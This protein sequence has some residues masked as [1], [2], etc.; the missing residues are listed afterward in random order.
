MSVRRLIL[1]CA[2]MAA[3]ALLLAALTPP[4]QAITDSLL[5]PQR[6]VDARGADAL[7]LSAAG[8]ASWA[9]WA[10]ATLG[11]ALTTASAVP[12]VLGVPAQVLLRVVLPA[13]ARRAAALALGLGL[14]APVVL[15]APVGGHRVELAVTTTAASVPDWPRDDDPVP[16]WPAAQPADFHVVV[17]GD[18]LWD[19]VEGRLARSGTTPTDSVIAGAVRAWWSANDQVIGPNPDLILPGQVLRAPQP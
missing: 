18:C 16:D 6:T 17:R 13:G 7:L 15:A 10:Y 11:L 4:L 9:V 5:H 2:A 3:A 12:S 8:L 1:T 19:I 14:A